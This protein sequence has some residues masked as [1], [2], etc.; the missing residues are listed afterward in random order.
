MKSILQ[1]LAGAFVGL[2]ILW[3]INLIAPVETQYSYF[4]PQFT[5]TEGWQFKINRQVES[6]KE[7]Y[8]GACNSRWISCYYIMKSEELKPFEGVGSLEG[9]VVLGYDGQ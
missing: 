6:E 5:F 7:L 8:Q 3:S 9:D 1:F 4:K 2:M